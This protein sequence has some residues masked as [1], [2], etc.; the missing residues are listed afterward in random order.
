MVIIQTHEIK[1]GALS[2]G[3]ACTRR[4][5]GESEGVAGLNL[6]GGASERTLRWVRRPQATQSG[7]VHL[8]PWVGMPCMSWIF[9]LTLLMMSDDSTLRIIL[10]P[11]NLDGDLSAIMEM[12]AQAATDSFGMS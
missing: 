8:S 5:D 10:I 7:Q 1:L 12:E 6:N 11:V 9:A 3:V 2:T 4:A